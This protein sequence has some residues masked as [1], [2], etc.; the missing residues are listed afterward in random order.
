M[1]LQDFF[2]GVIRTGVIAANSYLDAEIK[3][4]QAEDAQSREA[5]RTKLME[6]RNKMLRQKENFDQLMRM[7]EFQSTEA[8]RQREATQAEEKRQKDAELETARKTNITKFGQASSTAQANLGKYRETGTDEDWEVFQ[9]SVYHAQGLGSTMGD[10]VDTGFLG[11]MLEKE[12]EARD[13]SRAET[14]EADKKKTL[15]RIN[16]TLVEYGKDTSNPE[17]KQAA[18][19][20]VL[21]GAAIDPMYKDL[22]DKH[23]PDEDA[24]AAAI[25]NARQQEPA[26]KAA[27]EQSMSKLLDAPPEQQD[28]LK[29]D[30]YKTG[31]VYRD[32]R[33]TLG[34]DIQLINSQ[35]RGLG[36]TDT[37]TQDDEVPMTDEE[38]DGMKTDIEGAVTAK[39]LS[40]KEA[41]TLIAM[42][43]MGNMTADEMSEKI[44]DLMIAG[45]QPDKAEKETLDD[46]K[47]KYAEKYPIGSPLSLVMQKLS[48]S[49]SMGT[50]LA[51]DNLMTSD[52]DGKE[53]VRRLDD[54]SETE[55][56]SLSE[57]I[58]AW[59]E[60]VSSAKG[61]ILSRLDSTPIRSL[62][63]LA[64]IFQTY[65][66]VRDELSLITF[67]KEGLEKLIGTA[68]NE[69]VRMFYVKLNEYLDSDTRLRS[70]AQTA[71]AEVKRIKGFHPNMKNVGDANDAIFKALGQTFRNQFAQSYSVDYGGE[72]GEILSDYAYDRIFKIAEASNLK[73]TNFE[74]LPPEASP[75]E[76]GAM[77]EKDYA[78][79]APIVIN[80]Y[81]GLV[82]EDLDK[83]MSVEESRAEAKA[84][85]EKM[86]LSDELIEELLNAMYEGAGEQ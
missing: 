82:Q 14:A 83:G 55:L 53:A 50:A 1:A 43:D 46:S 16:T 4:L 22:F 35:L 71:E 44:N 13:Q 58:L 57:N 80:Y 78:E 32:I 38:W 42:G 85:F 41:D 40:R 31:V 39:L 28:A 20:A 76:F 34:K 6:E 48:T 29:E 65:K 72:M 52:V 79:D 51:I 75:E 3:Y 54:L 10:D 21:E 47:R 24:N 68:S 74:I 67:S 69:E 26:A 77:L 61:E 49:D 86:N 2:E 8:V 5:A 12:T 63:S 60:S 81:K 45:L 18:M 84:G 64:S 19:A 59:H 56:G 73:S 62:R 17:K 11:K 70:G 66:G 27:F 33:K 25:A 7:K 9:S 37:E 30:V 15:Q 23:F 36:M